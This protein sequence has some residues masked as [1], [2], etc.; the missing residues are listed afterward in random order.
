[1]C[2]CCFVLKVSSLGFFV[3]IFFFFVKIVFSTCY[4]ANK[5][6]LKRRKKGGGVVSKVC[7]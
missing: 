4:F 6:A 5:Y 7:V 3:K 1:M 2:V